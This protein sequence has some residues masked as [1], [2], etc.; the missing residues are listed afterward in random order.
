MPTPCPSPHPRHP[1]SCDLVACIADPHSHST[2]PIPTPL[3]LHCPRALLDLHSVLVKWSVL[4][5]NWGV[6]SLRQKPLAR[7]GTLLQ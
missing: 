3:R 7:Q 4:P 5:R 2:C 1:L 6:Q